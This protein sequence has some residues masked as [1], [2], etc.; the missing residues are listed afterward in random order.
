MPLTRA[1][2]GIATWLVLLAVCI[3]ITFQRTRFTTDLT[4]F[5]PKSASPAQELLISQLRD[6]IASRLILI[7]IEGP[8]V[9]SLVTTSKALVREI[10]K[11]PRFSYVANGE[12]ALTERDRAFLLEHRYALSPGVEPDRFTVAGLKA[13][14]ADAMQAL[15]S[16]LGAMLRP[17][18][19]KDPSGEF[20]RVLAPLA[21]RQRPPTRGGVW[22]TADGKRALLMAETK[23]AGFDA[24]PQEM[25]QNEI[26][27]A[28]RASQADPS[29]RLIMTGPAV[30]ALESRNAIE[31]DALMLSLLATGLVVLI[32]AVAYR[33]AMLVGFAMIP[34][35]T[36]AFAAIAAVS[37]AFGNVHGITLG[38]GA[39]LIG[40]AVDY[41]TYLFTQRA[42]GESPRVVARRIWPTLRLAVMT[43]VFGSIA[44]L[45]SSF[46]GLAQLGLFTLAGVLVAGL[47]T[48]FVLPYLVPQRFAGAR[49]LPAPRAFA[50]VVSAARRLRGVVIALLVISIGILFA[51]RSTLWESDITKVNPI[52]EWK[53]A[54]DGELRDAL[55]APD[56]RVFLAVAA[57]DEDAALAKCEAIAPIL[58]AL[59]A[60]GR[61][62]R[63]DS[64]A[65]YLPSRSTQAA[66]RAALPPRA[67]LAGRMAEAVR[68]SPFREDLFGPFLD[69]VERARTAPDLTLAAMQGTVW[70]LA[71]RSYLVAQSGRVVA[72]LPL[73]GVDDPKQLVA[74]VAELKDP[75]LFA[76]Y[77]HG[78]S[79]AMIDAY[80]DE[81]L[82]LSLLGVALIATVLGIGL[83]SR[84]SVIGVLTP[85]LAAMFSTAAILALFEVRLSVFHLVSLLLVLGIGVNYALF[86]NRDWGVESS[87]EAGDAAGDSSDYLRTAVSVVIANLTTVCAFGAL[88]FSETPILSSI[89]TTVALGAVL[90]LVFSAAWAKRV[91]GT[92]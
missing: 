33:S 36:G 24:V 16:P 80:R 68:D 19:A 46:S 23:A 61:M 10:A 31:H 79:N 87:S 81:S 57:P 65:S 76:F 35:L 59:I 40:E 83:R 8:E 6:G 85:V 9:K 47:V 82:L 39:T 11:S 91:G 51:L 62:Q 86:F 38:F 28:F 78:E 43:T 22:I 41:P 52:P 64:P 17:I 66:R 49:A 88:T 14:L 90:S 7:A 58:Q 2:L 56:A 30:F 73:V 18:L 70:G 27:A 29:L 34:V 25:A 84:K 71:V 77:L 4:A 3:G 37:L 12:E 92:P 75:T 44:M 53:K 55:G 48:R 1:R 21:D 63:Y 15:A 74:R 50:T 42:P 13:S 32:L 89:G 69:D 20:A 45:F 5:L 67:E 60:E 54:L 26:V 72:L